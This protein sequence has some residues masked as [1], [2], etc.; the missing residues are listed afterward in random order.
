M[1]RRR[2]L[3]SLAALVLAVVVGGAGCGYSLRPSLPPHIKTVHIPVLRNR[4][5]EPGIETFVTQALTEAFVTSGRIRLAASAREADAI[6]EGAI[7]GYSLTALAFDRTANVTEY[8][9]EIALALTLHDR[10]N[11]VTLWKHDRLQERADFR[12]P[13]QVTQT[14]VREETAL[15]QAAVDI[16]RTIVSLA[17]E[18]F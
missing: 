3:R 17:L 12:V 11:D 2:R 4:T 13:G 8:R 16:S 9:L 10:R 1:S 7:I 5:A 6:L 18:G 15:K 14:L